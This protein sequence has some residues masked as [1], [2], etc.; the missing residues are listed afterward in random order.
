M[1]DTYELDEI[2]VITSHDLLDNYQI[3][4]CKMYIK[5]VELTSFNIKE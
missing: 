4:P 5:F 2:K 1:T 3:K